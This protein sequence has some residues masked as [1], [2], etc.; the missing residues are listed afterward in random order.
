MKNPN[1]TPF[2]NVIRG[3]VQDAE[4]ILEMERGTLNGDF[5]M[6]S[7][8]VKSRGLTILFVDFP[9][10]CSNLERSLEVGIY[11]PM[12]GAPF[13]KNGFPTIFGAIYAKIFDGDWL[14]LLE[15]DPQAVRVL[16]QLLRVYKKFDIAC[17]PSRVKEKINDFFKIEEG[18]PDPVLSWGRRDLVSLG[19][20]PCLVD[21]GS[22]LGHNPEHDSELVNAPRIAAKREREI[23]HDL[24]CIQYAADRIVR[25]FKFKRKGFEPRHG[26]GAVSEQYENSKFEFPSWPDRLEK[27]FAF[28]DYG[29]I[30]Y[31][32]AD[33]EVP[34]EEPER[35]PPCKL[36]DVPKDYK[37]PRLIASEPIS[38][39]FVQQGL[40]HILRDSVKSSVLRHCI[41]FRS[42]EPSRQL[43]L[44]ASSNGRFATID[45][46]SASDRLSCALVECIFRSNYGFLELLNA[47]RTPDI[48]YPDGSVQTMKKFAAQGAAFT[49]PVQTIVYAIICMGVCFSRYKETNMAALARLVRVYGDDMIVP[50]DVFYPIVDVMERLSLKVNQEKSF[51][52]GLFKESC[53][54]DAYNGQ[55]VT[56]AS[57]RSHFRDRDC[58]SLVSV[59]ECA[60]NLYLKGFIQGSS[61]LLDTIPR[62][63]LRRIPVKGSRSTT[64]GLV[65]GGRRRLPTR[66][67]A[68]WQIHEVKCL[69][70]AS[71][72]RKTT[73]G[74]YHHLHQWFIE[75]PPADTVWCAGEAD[76]TRSSYRSQWVAE[77][78]LFGQ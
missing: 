59:V 16:R 68:N 44:Q 38:S 27:Y 76:G 78:D 74:G 55:D 25:S 57:V 18:L 13:T 21:L 73:P 43:V 24:S 14:P 20:Y 71:K 64:F 26:P 61:A 58:E 48:L 51:K 37:G 36:I 77:Q 9:S 10:A 66:W 47:A 39:Q 40:M 11:L 4:D 54:M 22:N 53:G 34:Y 33:L 2:L 1:V 60:N 42:Q 6:I 50:V 67:N 28:C 46:S 32:A 56:P 12:E 29:L 17:P 41:D 31:S 7:K 72:V 15:P 45:L 63:L 35:G 30:N 62:K 65:G 75:N 23:A 19:R 70:V 5:E 3:L 69:T 8:S 49:F 52:W